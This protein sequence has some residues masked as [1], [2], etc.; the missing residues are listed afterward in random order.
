MIYIA[1]I[2]IELAVFGVW[3]KMNPLELEDIFK[4]ENNEYV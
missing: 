1:I 4:T 3:S 2:L